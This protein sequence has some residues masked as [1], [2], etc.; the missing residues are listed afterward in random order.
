MSNKLNKN[1]IELLQYLHQNFYNNQMNSRTI[2]SLSQSTNL[3]Y[4]RLRTMINRLSLL[5]LVSHGFKEGNSNTFYIT[6][7]G[8]EKIESLTVNPT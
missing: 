4:F 2:K 3:N 5:E 1:E 8:I 6:I 7:K